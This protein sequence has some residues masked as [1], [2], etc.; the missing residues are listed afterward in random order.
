MDD[1]R[2]LVVVV[3]GTRPVSNGAGSRSTNTGVSRGLVKCCA[4]LTATLRPRGLEDLKPS[5]TE[6]RPGFWPTPMDSTSCRHRVSCAGK[7]LPVVHTPR[8]HMFAA[9]VTFK[10]SLMS[11][12]TIKPSG[13]SVSLCA[14]VPLCLCL[15]HKRTPSRAHPVRALMCRFAIHD[16][17]DRGQG[18][19][20]IFCMPSY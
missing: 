4:D 2:L 19:H 17:R 20:F 11:A 3:A 9:S 5:H 13:R 1:G 15:Y 14:C 10:S 16:S 12:L 8:L 18:Y 6:S 7:R